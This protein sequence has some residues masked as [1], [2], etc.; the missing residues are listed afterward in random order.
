VVATAKA[1]GIAM[2]AIAS[3]CGFPVLIKSLILHPLSSLRLLQA[4]L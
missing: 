2:F 3:A 4:M 1:T